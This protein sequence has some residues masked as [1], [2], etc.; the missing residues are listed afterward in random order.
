MRKLTMDSLQSLIQEVK[1][2]LSSLSLPASMSS[3]NISY[4]TVLGAGC[5]AYVTLK[6]V[7]FYINV[8]KYP[9][10]PFPL[11]IVGN[12]PYLKTKGQHM[13]DAMKKY[14]E[15]YGPVFT[16]WLGPKPQI[17]VYDTELGLQVLKSKTFSGRPHFVIQDAIAAKPGSITLAFGDHSKEWEVLKKVTFAAVA[18]FTSSPSLNQNVVHVVD[19][20]VDGM[21]QNKESIDFEETTVNLVVAFLATSVF[22]VK[23]KLEDKELQEIVNTMEMLSTESQVLMLIGLS[24]SIRFVIWSKWQRI[25]KVMGYF[26]DLVGM[27]FK[28]REDSFRGQKNDT[29]TDSILWARNQAEAEDG[30]DILKYIENPNLRNAVA[31]MFLAGSHAIRMTLMWWFLYSALNQDM[32]EKIRKEVQQVLPGEND[33][34][35]LQM[36]DKCPFLVAFTYEVMRLK[37]VAAFPLPHKAL[38]QASLGSHSIPSGA[39][40]LVSVHHVHQD[41]SV[42]KEGDKF[43]PD[44][45]I[46]S[47][48]GKFVMKNKD[49][50]IPFSTGIRACVGEKLA[51]ES[52]FLILLRFFQKTRGFRLEVT[53]SPKNQEEI[54][55]L[56]SADISKVSFYETKNYRLKLSQI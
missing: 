47:K 9:P 35:D 24:S 51:I 21:K 43:N 8:R 10:G 13:H 17:F 50:L 41:S 23:Y 45:F 22:G 28:E 56:L 26:R 19:Q 53:P 40:V 34:P 36:K 42:W 14:S 15:V 37:S 32:Q 2:N 49:Y 25:L 39:T 30:K 20:I 38:D 31:N 33:I 4:V 3:E 6:T 1:Q 44:R 55:E 52:V 29:I 18:R 48:T 27:R 12:V 5:L 46:D 11:P 54:D 16:I 7:C